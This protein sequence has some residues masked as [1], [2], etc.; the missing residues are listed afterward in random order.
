MFES[1]FAETWR[2]WRSYRWDFLPLFCRIFYIFCHFAYRSLTSDRVL[3]YKGR[4]LVHVLC[5]LERAPTA[6]SKTQNAAFSWPLL[7]KFV[8]LSTVSH[9]HVN[10]DSNALKR[11]RGS[12]RG[13]EDSRKR[14]R[15]Q[16]RAQKC[17][18][19]FA[20]TKNFWLPAFSKVRSWT[21]TA[22]CERRVCSK[23]PGSQ[24][25]ENVS[26]S[27]FHAA[28]AENRKRTELVF[29][30]EAKFSETWPKRNHVKKR[31]RFS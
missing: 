5:F 16:T 27:S 20:K 6:G 11:K 17:A 22:Q 24:N 15:S 13:G 19:F 8:F 9:F 25:Y 2:G 31:A 18:L 14:K 28:H 26:F 7:G 29:R 4:I 30:V 3:D 21:L 10:V 23:A 12:P 1:L